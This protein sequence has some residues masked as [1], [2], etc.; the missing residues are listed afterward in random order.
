MSEPSVLV[1]SQRAYGLAEGPLWDG[2]RERVL[3]VDINAG[4]VLAG[5]LREGVIDDAAPLVGF[6]ETVGA[7]VCEEH[8]QLLIAGA[9]SVFTP[10]DPDGASTLF[11]ASK[12]SRLND[13]ACDPAGRF[14]VG[15]M[16]LDDREGEERLHRIELDGSVTIVDHDL[17]LSNGLAWSPDGSV[18]YSVDTTPG[19]VYARPYDPG[20][21]AYGERTV[22]LR[23]AGESPDGLCTDAGGNLWIAIWGAG[24]VRC[25]TPSGELVETVEVPAPHVTS[26]AFIGPE[27]DTLLITSAHE[28]ESQNAGHLFSACV[29]VRGTPTTPWAGV[30]R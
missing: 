24:Q 17:T 18:L 1:A 12:N 8:G 6:D 29:G 7:V 4:E 5:S 28:D 20:S 22:A 13:G 26:V 15:S 23:I 27:L 14:L 11:D 2:A 30:G 3:W 16:A 9:R 10:G 25:Y 19:I 21:G